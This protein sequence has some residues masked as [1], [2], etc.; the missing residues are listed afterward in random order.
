MLTK[1]I[2]R[3]VVIGCIA[4]LGNDWL[5]RKVSMSLIDE[6]KEAQVMA[7]ENAVLNKL[8]SMGLSPSSKTIKY[9][10]DETSLRECMARAYCHK[11]NETKELDATLIESMIRE[12]KDACN[13]GGA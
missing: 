11:E 6:I 1:K 13:N 12:I 3:S 5:R 8:K 9:I 7:G 2:T 4:G 10:I